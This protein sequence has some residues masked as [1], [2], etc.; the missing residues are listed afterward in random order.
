MARKKERS[1]FNK[2]GYIS[3]FQLT[4]TA[5]VNDN[6]FFLDQTSNKSN[7]I[8][9]RMNL[10]VSCGDQNGT[11]YANAMGGFGADRENVIYV[12][13]RTQ[14]G[15]DDFQNRWTVNFEDRNNPDIIKE[16]GR[17]CY[18]TAGLE[19]DNKGQTVY[20][21]F[22]S[23]YDMIQ[24]V[25]E[26]L[27]TGTPITVRGN[28]EFRI[29]NGSTTVQLNITNIALSGQEPKDYKARFTQTLLLDSDCA[30]KPDKETGEMDITGY[31]LEYMKEYNGHDLSEGEKKGENVPLPFIFKYRVNLANPELAKKAVKKLFAVKRGSVN[32]ITFEGD[33]VNSGAT[34]VLGLSELPDDIQDLVSL[35]IMSEEEAIAACATNGNRERKLILQKPRIRNVQDKDGVST[36]EVMMV[37]DAYSEED[38]DYFRSMA[39]AEEPEG[40]IG[41]AMP[42]PVDEPE[43]VDFESVVDDDSMDWLSELGE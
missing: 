6:T 24:Y 33:F 38:L 35:G 9:N 31:V 5:L 25:S 14:D 21:N 32:Q 13:G 3:T 10:G 15:M 18:F 27:E 40:D 34:I 11:V 20:K 1:E 22:L 7:W 2:K 39:P 30:G 29:Y 37:E 26:H 4:G 12:H 41:D 36:P 28:M 23:A 42:A 43:E 16:V 19:K 8:Y 17:Q